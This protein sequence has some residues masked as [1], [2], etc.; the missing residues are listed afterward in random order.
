MQLDQSSEK[1]KSIKQLRVQL[2]ALTKE[3]S[4]TTE[5]LQLLEIQTESGKSP[6]D[7]S[8]EEISSLIRKQNKISHEII[9]V[10]KRIQK[11]SAKTILKVELMVLPILAV[12]LF[13]GIS[14]QYQS[15]PAD[16]SNNIKTHYLIENLQGEAGYTHKYWNVATGTPLTVSIVNPDHMSQEKINVIKDAILSTAPIYIDNSLLDK[17]PSNGKSEYYKGWKGALNTIHDTEFSIPNQFNI[18]ESDNGPGQ[19]VIT[20]SHLEDPDGYSGYTRSVV[21]DSQILKSFITI[22]DADK[23]SDSQLAIVVR[24]EFGHALGLP[25]S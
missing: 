5:Q 6:E 8:P 4:K 3:L 22:Y 24:H 7:M 17:S 16:M 12:L 2:L 11:L 1:E 25:H 23:L 20:L 13:Y 18:V 21:D 15:S 9:V 19:I 10:K 14:N